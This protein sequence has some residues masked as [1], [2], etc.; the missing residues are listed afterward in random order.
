MRKILRF[1]LRILAKRLL[2]KYKPVIVAVTGSVGKT[3]TKEA[4]FTVIQ[5]SFPAYR[6][7]GNYNTDIGV[8]LSIVATYDHQVT[9]SFGYF[10]ALCKGFGRYLTRQKYPKILVLEYAADRPGEIRYLVKH[11]PPQIAVVTAIGEIPVHLEYYKSRAEIVAEKTALVKNLKA[12]DTAVLNADE[13]DVLDMKNQTKAKVVTCGLS[14]DAQIRASGVN[15]KSGEN[16]SEWGL[17]FKLEMQGKVVPVFVQGVIGAHM[18]YSMLAAAAVGERLNVGVLEIVGQMQEIKPVAGRM[19]LLAGIK[20][21]V[22]IDDTYNSSPIAAEKALEALK[23]VYGKRKIAVLGDML[24][25]GEKTEDAHRKIGLEAAKNNVDY[26]V[27]VGLRSKFMAETGRSY[28]MQSD[29]ILSFENADEAR[30]PIQNLLKPGDTVLVKGSQGMRMEKI[31]KEIMSEPEKAGSL[32]V[33]QTKE[34][35]NTP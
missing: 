26:L 31:V 19:N 30:L 23:Q 14:P 1:K 12:D 8:P 24:E 5:K 4:I 27:T 29:R 13:W 16:L 33:R 2:R 3:T 9:G 11:F 17:Q 21:T 22:I 35:L 10:L 32:L 28:G 25:L 34:W 6:S 15:I 18:V 7:F 20:N